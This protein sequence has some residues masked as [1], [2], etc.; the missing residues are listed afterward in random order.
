MGKQV[1][2]W[3]AGSQAG[4][5][6]GRHA[7]LISWCK[8]D[9]TT[10]LKLAQ[11]GVEELVRCRHTLQQ[12]TQSIERQV[13]AAALGFT[14]ARGLSLALSVLLIWPNSIYTVASRH[15][16]VGDME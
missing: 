7:A 11:A 12:S 6:A 10:H 4:G 15:L 1:G 5:Q 3:A 9:S 13:E 8:G 2:G 16:D 14:Q